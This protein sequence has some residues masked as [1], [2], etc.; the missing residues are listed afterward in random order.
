MPAT[1]GQMQHRVRIQTQ[2]DDGTTVDQY[3]QPIP[4]WVNGITCWARVRPPTGRE[5]VN[6]DQLK[7]QLSQVV[8]VRYR[9]TI[10][11]DQQLVYE[12]RVFRISYVIPDENNVQMDLYCVESL[13]DNEDP[14][15]P[16]P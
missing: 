13:G 5:Q 11:K 14:T 2:V 10:T 8:T 4:A 6:A 7:V 12:G 9:D 15:E 3:G 1:L 16:A